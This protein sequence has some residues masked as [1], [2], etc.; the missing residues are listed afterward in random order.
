MPARATRM[1]IGLLGLLL[2]APFLGNDYLVSVLILCLFNAYLAQTW[3]IM[4][5]FAGQLSLGHALYVGL[6]AYAG[7]ALFFHYGTPPWIGM[8]VGA[9]IAALV[10]GVIGFLG[11]RF[12]VKGVYFALLT[13]AFAEFTRILFDHFT[14]VG[15]SSGLYLP[16]VRADHDNLLLLRGRPA[17]FYY[18]ILALSAAVF[19]ICH[20]IL[21]SR[22]GY[23]WR[24]IREDQDAAQALGI[25]TFKAKMAAV[26]LSAAL[27]AVGGVF[28]AFYYN[29][30]YAESAF[31]MH[32][33][34]E[35]ILGAIIGGLGTLFGPILGAFLLT[36]LGELLTR[37]AENFGH[38]FEGIKQIGYGL[39]LLI[40]IA[41]R[42][43]GVWPRLAKRLGLDGEKAP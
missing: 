7:G 31:A 8:I 24:A 25:D 28:Y 19:L 30:L 9:A 23:Y 12:G 34:I 43:E 42:R 21:G 37:L 29:T 17:M 4:M 5:G 22:L 41:L 20:R 39:I 13:I 33:S 1:L 15:A 27:T 16:V 35:L 6:G 11:F 2:L 26:M 18:V 10:G 3:N 14:W 32:R 40:I 38:G 36:L